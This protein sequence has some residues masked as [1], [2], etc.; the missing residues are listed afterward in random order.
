MLGRSAGSPRPSPRWTTLPLCESTSSSILSRSLASRESS[1]SPPLSQLPLLSSVYNVWRVSQPFTLAVS[2]PVW[3]VRDQRMH[4]RV[5]NP[6][7][8]I[9]VPSSTF[10]LTPTSNARAFRSDRSARFL[11]RYSGRRCT[12]VNISSLLVSIYTYLT[13]SPTW[14]ILRAGF[15]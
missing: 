15:L 5:V 4:G 7:S 1:C 11:Q 10:S 13:Q 14:P 12:V 3:A 8:R 9:C 2:K 6:R